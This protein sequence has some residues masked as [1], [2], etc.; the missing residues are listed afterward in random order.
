MKDLTKIVAASAVLI[1]A[2]GTAAAAQEEPEV[3]KGKN[4]LEYIA[5]VVGDGLDARR[6]DQVTVHYTGWLTDGTKFDSS[7][8][9]GQTIEFALN[10]VIAGWTEGVGSMKVGGKRKLI[11]PADLGYGAAG[12]GGLIPGGATLIFDVELVSTK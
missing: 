11:I 2:L 6:G 3:V 5:L 12:A 4:G 10:G 7:V 9:R 8:D 1:L